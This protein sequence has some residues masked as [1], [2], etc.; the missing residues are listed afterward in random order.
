M[1]RIIIPLPCHFKKSD[2]LC[3]TTVA[4]MRA[5]LT[6]IRDGDVILL[7][8]DVP[9]V[10]GGPTLG[11]LM[12]D[13]FVEHGFAEHTLHTLK[14]VYGTFSEARTA[15]RLAKDIGVEELVVISSPWY[16]FA[17]I[18]IWKKRA[19]ENG[20]TVSFISVPHTGGLRTWFLYGVIG[21]IIRTATV[22]GMEKR[23][24]NFFTNIQKK[25]A[26]GFTFNGC[27]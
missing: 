4:R 15:C 8:G 14:E 24:E 13:W 25:R 11:L 26:L 23:C 22:M 16:F 27:A 12:R 9:C 21:I 18:P 19:K 6:V 20:I 3:A 10:P 5:A 7:T 17:G 2:E 1:S